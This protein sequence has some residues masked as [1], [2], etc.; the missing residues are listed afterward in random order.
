[1]FLR[2]RTLVTGGAGF[3]G[4]HLCERLLD[5]GHEVVCVDNSSPARRTTSRIYWQIPTSSSFAMT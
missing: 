5:M 2:K 3:L 1:M 4:S